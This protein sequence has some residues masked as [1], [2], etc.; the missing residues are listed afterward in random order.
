MQCRHGLLKSDP[1]MGL[2]TL[3]FKR[4]AIIAASSLC[5]YGTFSTV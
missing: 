5:P 3:V 1:F 2:G 4:C